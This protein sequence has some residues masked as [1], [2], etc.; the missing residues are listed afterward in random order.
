MNVWQPIETAPKDGTRI[1]LMQT[2]NKHYERLPKI[3]FIRSGY[4]KGGIFEGSQEGW[5]TDDFRLPYLVNFMPFA[6]NWWMPL[7][8]ID[9]SMLQQHVPDIFLEKNT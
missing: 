8:E 3:L 7:P 1:L 5:V 2:K 9:D 6:A 4:W